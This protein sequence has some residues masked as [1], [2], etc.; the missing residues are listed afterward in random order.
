MKSTKLLMSAGVLALMAGP[1]FAG[2]LKLIVKEVSCIDGPQCDL[3]GGAPGVA[4]EDNNDGTPDVSRGL[5]DFEELD[6]PGSPTIENSL[7][8]GPLVISGSRIISEDKPLKAHVEVDAKKVDRTSS[9][10]EDVTQTTT[11]A[12]E[13]AH[14][15]TTTQ[16]STIVRSGGDLTYSVAAASSGSTFVPGDRT[17]LSQPTEGETGARFFLT[18]SDNDVDIGFVLPI[19]VKDCESGDIT[20]QVEFF[21]IENGAG[22]VRPTGSPFG[23]D[24]NEDPTPIFTCGG[25]SIDAEYWMT[26]PDLF[27]SVDGPNAEG[28]VPQ[29]PFNSFIFK[30]VNK[31]F[32]VDPA[33]PVGKLFVKITNDLV[34][35]KK[36]TDDPDRVFE[37]T[38]IQTYTASFT[39]ED[40]SS[41]EEIVIFCEDQEDI[42]EQPVGN[43]VTFVLDEND[44]ANCFDNDI[45]GDGLL[46]GDQMVQD[47]FMQFGWADLEIS[48]DDDES[49]DLT[50]QEVTVEVSIDLDDSTHDPHVM[51]IDPGITDAGIAFRIAQ[52]GLNFGP[53]DW[54]TDSSPE[55]TVKSI[56]RITGV[57]VNDP[58][59]GDAV[60]PPSL[61]DGFLNGLVFITNTKNLQD[62][63]CDVAIP[64]DPDAPSAMGVIGGTGEGLI[65]DAVLQALIDGGTCYANDKVNVPTSNYGRADI[66]WSFYD[67][68]FKEGIEIDVDRLLFNPNTGTF[69]AYG[70]NGNDSNSIKSLSC[71]DGRFGPHSANLIEDFERALFQTGQGTLPVANDFESLLARCRAGDLFFD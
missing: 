34:D 63:W 31:G 6:G 60:V 70:D 30:D 15:K 39:F 25:P 3:N 58:E 22:L 42:F 64:I 41:I 19:L 14:F 10:T 13:N 69:A 54:V 28:D 62:G 57:P 71:D 23:E 55:N 27:T 44:I 29:V 4:E 43:V 20:A 40:A 5:L 51:F 35:A 49:T 32:E 68:G 65:N 2:P 37:Y 11:I 8:N 38:D 45:D 61:E 24:G 67:L 33:R 26:D 1:A 59:K 52:V 66:K 56:F 50:N 18:P 36:K 12:L 47:G 46:V 48:A 9:F 16:A 17:I 53:F 21:S 7:L